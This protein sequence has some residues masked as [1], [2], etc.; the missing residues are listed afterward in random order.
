M[1]NKKLCTSLLV[2]AAVTLL[3]VLAF[4]V[5]TGVT[6]DSI[7]ILQTTGMTCGSCSTEI[8]KA[9]EREK[10]VAVTEVDVAG[11]WV[12]IGYDTKTVKPEALAQKVSQAGFSS[13]L[14]AILT[15]EEFKRIAG[16]EVGKSA[17]DAKSCCGA[18]NGGCGGNK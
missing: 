3:L 16:R 14:Y 13:N 6:A 15:P 5:R 1:S 10:G 17:S 12:V 7:A 11:G 9:I 2:I 8:T 4:H 18:N